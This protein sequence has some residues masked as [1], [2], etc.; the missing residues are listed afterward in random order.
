M[1]QVVIN[2]LPSK[3]YARSEAINI[4]CTNLSFAGSNVRKIMVTSTHAGEG[5]STVAIECMRKMAELSHSAVLVDADLRRSALVSSYG[6]QFPDSRGK[7]LAHYLVGRA[8]IDD[9]LY[10]TNVPG[11]YMVPV[12]RTVS[13]PLQLLN[14][15]RFRELLESLAE[16]MDYVLVDTPPLGLVI[17]AAEIAKSCDGSLIVVDY[18]TVH[19]RELQDVKSQLEQTGCPIL[20]VA[21]N[22]VDYNDY[23]SKKYYHKSY[24]SSDY[25]EYSR[26]E[27]TPR[28][29]QPVPKTDEKTE[30]PQ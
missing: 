17:D 16:K 3:S 2:K 10:E 30:Q 12:G 20:G 21:L 8:Q 27:K 6:L 11:A 26:Y 29:K 19:R 24:Y 25:Y 23:M 4:L 13:N 22:K 28:K 15:D 5:K 1:K 7:G 9:I 14:L 18:N